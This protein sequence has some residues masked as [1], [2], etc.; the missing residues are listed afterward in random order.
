MNK[1]KHNQGFT[2]I[3][4]LVAITILMIAI[5]GPLVVASKGSAGAV[6]ARNQMIASYMAQESMEGIKNIKDNN[7]AG[8]LAW[9]NGFNIGS[10]CNAPSAPCDLSGIDNPTLLTSGWSTLPDGTAVYPIVVVP[11]GYYSHNT[12]AVGSRATLFS[13]YFYL[14]RISDDEYTAVVAVT[15]NEGLT[16]YTV[17]ISSQITNSP[18]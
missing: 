17:S 9:L 7:I 6:T 2:I 18:R 1:I 14:T 5:S 4:T 12:G 13:R 3:E 16:P 11:D 10:T 8:S 15:W